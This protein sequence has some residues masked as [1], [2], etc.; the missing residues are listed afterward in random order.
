MLCGGGEGG[1]VICGGGGEGAVI[2][3]GG[4]GGAVLCGGGTEG[5][6]SWRALDSEAF[7]KIEMSNETKLHKI[8]THRGPPTNVLPSEADIERDLQ[9]KPRRGR[10]TSSH[11]V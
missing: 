4:E 5:A 11:E 8:I 6:E 10:S 9:G 2:C 1:A 3:R 7:Q